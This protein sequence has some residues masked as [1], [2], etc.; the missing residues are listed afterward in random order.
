MM[1]E[2]TQN[3]QPTCLFAAALGLALGIPSVS[4]AATAKSIPKVDAQTLAA[5][6]HS[7]RVEVVIGLEDQ[8]D[9]RQA[10]AIQ[11]ASAR[12]WYVFQTLR[13]TA[14]RSQTDLLSWL[15][16]RGQ[17]MQ[18]FWAINAVVASVD[19]PTLEQLAARPDV[20]Y[21]EANAAQRWIEPDSLADRTLTP[22]YL[23]AAVEWGVQAVN[24]PQVWALGSYGQGIVIG[25]ADTGMQWDHP[26]IKTQYRGYSVAGTVS[27]DYSWHDSIHGVTG[28]P[29]GSDAVAPCDDQGHGT[30]TTGT[31]VG[32]DG[33][34]NQIGVAPG[35]RWIGCRNMARGVGTP[36]R[37]I[38]CFQ[39][40]IA[41]TDGKG[42]NPNPDLRP[43]VLNNSWGCPTSEGCSV[44][45]LKMIVENTQA[46]GI[47]VEASAGNSGP[48]CSTVN[49]GP[50][51]FAAT[52]SVGAM[53]SNGKLA[54][55]SSRGPVTV[56]G[57]GR[58]KPELSAPGVRVRSCL[59]GNRY[60][61]L[62]G[63]SMAGPHVVGVIA[64]LWSARPELSRRI[65][66]TKALLTASANPTVLL[67]ATELCGGVSSDFFPNNSFGVGRV[68]ALAAVTW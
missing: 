15:S 65:A 25:N 32:D 46:A 4:F 26:A 53:D 37:Y 47:F 64:L 13:D 42:M 67:G 50:A 41:P 57:S 9:L 52:F 1:L 10:D 40:F 63:T 29:C 3:Q 21:I 2:R 35:A 24:A 33:M 38:E 11:D 8:A 58:M 5:L 27:H 12:G 34:G 44:N 18:R 31:V 48:A 28:N 68:D 20:R 54:G 43:H 59:P 17:V 39:F 36:A 14:D 7:D 56:D 61:S 30:H 62:S 16:Q 23:A 22:T 55:F 51:I 45:S 19:R 66:E 49:D 6:A 60:G